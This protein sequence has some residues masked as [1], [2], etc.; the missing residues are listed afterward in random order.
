MYFADTTTK[1]SVM[2]RVESVDSGATVFSFLSMYPVTIPDN[3]AEET[4][5]RAL[6]MAL[7]VIYCLLCPQWGSFTIHS[8]YILSKYQIALQ[9]DGAMS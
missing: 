3:N 4:L 2:G 7:Q 5:R 8:P 9:I 6:W 1:F